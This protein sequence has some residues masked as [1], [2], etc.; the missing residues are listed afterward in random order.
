MRLFSVCLIVLPAAL[1]Q[2]DPPVLVH[3]SF[4][5]DTAG[6]VVLGQGGR[7]RASGGA[8]EFTYEIKPKKFTLAV[9]PAPPETARVTGLRFRLKTD[10]DTAV[11]ILLSE[12]K[13]GGGNYTATL[14]SPAGAWQRIELAPN[15]FAAA[16]GPN[17]PVDADGRLDLDQVEGIGV[18]D[19]A[20]IV[21]AQP[22]NP[23]FPVAVERAS[24]AHT[25]QIADF[26][27]LGG[28]GTAPR[29]ELT[30]DHF[31]RGF[32]EW[33]TL[34]GVKLKLA[35]AGNP[36]RSAALEATYEQTAGRYGVVL[37]RLSNLDLSKA[38]GLAFEI[39]SRT[40]AIVIVS[41]ELKNGRRF[42]QTIYP[43][44]QGEVF[45]VRLQFSDFSGEGKLNPGQLK[46]LALTDVSAAESGGGNTNTLWIGRVEGVVK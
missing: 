16:D 43:P 7:V 37:R 19:I 4:A 33:I 20:Q 40:E 38:T 41:L 29:P 39:A 27:M 3:H 9:L 17:D 26:Q 6:W 42:N 44:G 46:S 14:W 15:D 1:A 30:I 12:R 24:G 28:T 22:D 34:G 10:H 45:P 35:G 25:L 11:A 36:L 5:T 23:E 13:P 8:L 2:P 31:D 21:S 32:L 18:V